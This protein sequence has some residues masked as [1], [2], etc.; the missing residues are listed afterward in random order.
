MY[1]ILSPHLYAASALLSV[2]HGE[3][4]LC[5]AFVWGRRALDRPLRRVSARGRCGAFD[6]ESHT[7]SGETSQRAA[8][9]F[10]TAVDCHWMPFFRDVHS[11][12]AVIAIIF[13]RDDGTAPG[14]DASRVSGT[15]FR[16]LD[17]KTLIFFERAVPNSPNAW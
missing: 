10:Y 9:P 11:N 8:R 15:T 17:W 1:N 2:S 12:L 7:G 13:C 4:V 3:S 6:T 16:E 5:G 14:C